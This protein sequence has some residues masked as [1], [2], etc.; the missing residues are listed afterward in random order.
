MS[1]TVLAMVSPAPKMVSSDLGKLDA[2]RHLTVG[3]ACANAGALPAARIPAMPE[4]LRKLR[5]SIDDS[6]LNA[7]VFADVEHGTDPRN[8]PCLRR[9]PGPNRVNAAV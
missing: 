2:Q 3:A 5:R 8:L 1:L 4:C 9:R 7:G 6:S